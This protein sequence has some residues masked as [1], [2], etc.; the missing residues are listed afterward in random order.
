MIPLAMRSKHPLL[1]TQAPVALRIS[2]DVNG[3]MPPDIV[4]I[5][6]VNRSQ[7]D[8]ESVIG[9]LKF[10]RDAGARGTAGNLDVVTPGAA[11]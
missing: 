1:K 2:K 8:A 5:F 10:G 11:A 6:E 4:R 3:A 7:R 9:V